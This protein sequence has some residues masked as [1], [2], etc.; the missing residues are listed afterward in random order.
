LWGAFQYDIDVFSQGWLYYCLLVPA[1]GYF[2]FFV[3]K[4]VVLTAPIWIPIR[5]IFGGIKSLF[6]ISVNK[7]KEER[8]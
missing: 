2:I 6:S 7:K 3:L 8:G 5:M 4:W 1:I